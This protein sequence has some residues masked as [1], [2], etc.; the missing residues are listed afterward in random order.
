MA[1]VLKVL[2]QLNPAATTLTA[3]YTVPALTS[4][5]V[6][7]L[8][9]CNRSASSVTFRTSVAVAGA[10]DDVKQYLFYDV[11]LT[12]NSTF[13]AT[14]GVTLGAADVVRVYASTTGLSFSLFGVEVS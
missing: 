10:A 12:K 7:T 14:I 4:A 11:V 3:L 5:T 1:E 8:A 9:V 13:T 6:S 2:A